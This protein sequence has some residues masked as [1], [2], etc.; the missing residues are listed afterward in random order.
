MCTRARNFYF[1]TTTGDCHNDHHD[2]I[3]DAKA[4]SFNSTQTD[5]KY[6]VLKTFSSNSTFHGSRA[7]ACTASPVSPST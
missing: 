6:R 7:L 1:V 4:L 2:Q 5:Q 3:K